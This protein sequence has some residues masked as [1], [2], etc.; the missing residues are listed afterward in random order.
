MPRLYFFVTFKQSI[1]SRSILHTD[2]NVDPGIYLGFSLSLQT[3]FI[4][5]RVD[6]Q[7]SSSR[8][9]EV[10]RRGS[11]RARAMPGFFGLP[12]CRHA[13][14]PGWSAALGPTPGLLL[15]PPSGFGPPPPS[16]PSLLKSALFS[17]P[18]FSDTIFTSAPSSPAIFFG[19]SSGFFF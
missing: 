11:L 12:R 1:G 5:L 15:P 10:W 14:R 19:R 13:V 16:P 6:V 18:Q 8:A 9:W 17:P 2:C 3:M 7:A 4:F